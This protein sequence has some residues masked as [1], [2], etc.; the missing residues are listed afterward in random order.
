MKSAKR[1]YLLCA[2]LGFGIT[3]TT[4][5][6]CDNDSN[7]SPAPISG[8]GSEEAAAS[9]TMVDQLARPALNEGLSINDATLNAFNSA[10]P[11]AHLSDAAAPVR[12]EVVATLV[13]FKKLGAALGTTP[14]P[15]PAVTAGA[16]LPDVMRIDTRVNA[17]VGKAAYNAATSGDKGM[18]TG[19]RKLEDDVID[20][21]LSFLVA[22]D[23]TGKTVSDG[24]TYAG[25][26][27][28]SNQGHKMLNGQTARNGKAT[29]PFVAAP[30]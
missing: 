15:E 8:T 20:I 28:N 7:S 11:S 16:F 17:P 24:V 1:N 2:L 14:A 25:N 19:G 18:L 22:G 27:R 26:Y 10:P 5:S 4:L 6:S 12:D 21:T 9:S 30:N 29:F 3:T 13:A 23:A